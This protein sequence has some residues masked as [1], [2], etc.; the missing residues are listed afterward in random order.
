[1]AVDLGKLQRHLDDLRAL[2][3]PAAQFICP[4]TLQQVPVDALIDGHILNDALKV[5]SRKTVIQF[6]DVD[7][8]YGK[9]VEPFLVDYLNAPTWSDEELINKAG[10]DACIVAK[11]GRKFSTFVVHPAQAP[12]VAKLFPAI[13]IKDNKGSIFRRFIKAAPHELTPD[14]QLEAKLIFNEPAALGA[15]LKSAYLAMFYH[16]GYRYVESLNGSFL[17]RVLYRFYS[18]G[19]TKETAGNYFS[20]LKGAVNI[21]LND[22]NLAISFDSVVGKRFLFHFYKPHEYELLFGLSCLFKINGRTFF[23]TIPAHLGDR[24]WHASLGVYFDFLRDRTIPQIVRLGELRDGA[25]VIDSRP[26][27]THFDPDTG[28]SQHT[29]VGRPE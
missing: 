4:I 1:M 25:W 29:L 2:G 14:V 11:G 12:R 5:A 22:D 19:G 16:T 27:D 28:P 8:H 3:Y 15:F 23:V 17:R 7:H 20:H 18:E 24:E 10:R 26:I 6:A 9:T 21:V 13:S